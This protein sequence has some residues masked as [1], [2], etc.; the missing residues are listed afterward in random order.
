MTDPLTTKAA[1]VMTAMESL[2]TASPLV[3]LLLCASGYA[4]WRIYSD[5]KIERKDHREEMTALMDRTTSTIT[6]NTEVLARLTTI[7]EEQSKRL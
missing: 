4:L 7:L 3:F 1:P 6:H 2:A 5:G